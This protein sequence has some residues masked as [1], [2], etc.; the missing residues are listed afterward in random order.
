METMTSYAHM[1]RTLLG[2]LV[3]VTLLAGCG[4]A[5]DAP[6]AAGRVGRGGGGRGTGRRSRQPRPGVTLGCAAQTG[7]ST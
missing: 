7:Q 5:Q 2:S 1:I 4:A 6:P 3:A